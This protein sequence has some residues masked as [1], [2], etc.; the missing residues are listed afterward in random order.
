MKKI[1][2][3]ILIIIFNKSICLAADKNQTEINLKH[4]I[5]VSVD[6]DG[7]IVQGSLSKDQVIKPIKDYVGQIEYCYEH[8]LQFNPNFPSGNVTIQ[9]AVDMS[10]KVIDSIVKET[11]FADVN[12]G[13]C[14]NGVFRRMPF[15]E[16]NGKTQATYLLKFDNKIPQ[17]MTLKDSNFKA[18]Q[19]SKNDIAKV[20]G[21]NMGKVEKCY[22]DELKLKP[23]I[24][25]KLQV[26]FIIDVDGNVQ[27]SKIASTTMNDLP[28]ETCIS[29]QFKQMKFPKPIGNE[30]V[31][32]TYPLIFNLKP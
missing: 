23:E 9:F 13:G 7:A 25:G 18:D 10:G 19:I 16:S 30:I 6:N 27:T 20:I 11:Q 8:Q 2:F 24:K 1:V 28:T 21:D 12:F 32:V 22:E 17:Q 4:T 26:N 29:S 5:L 31:E 15:P 3:T 14:V